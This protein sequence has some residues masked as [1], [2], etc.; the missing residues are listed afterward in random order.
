MKKTT[1]SSFSKGICHETDGTNIKK[2][3]RTKPHRTPQ[4]A[5]EVK[6]T[7]SPLTVGQSVEC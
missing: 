5:Q 2:Q 6:D 3:N 4:G 7:T 1:S